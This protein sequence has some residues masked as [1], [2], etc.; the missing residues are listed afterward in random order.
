MRKRTVYMFLVAL[1]NYYELQG[2]SDIEDVFLTLHHT[3]YHMA[4]ITYTA[5]IACEI[6]FVNSASTGK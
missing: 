2:I 1:Y 6:T 5:E 3:S 4:M